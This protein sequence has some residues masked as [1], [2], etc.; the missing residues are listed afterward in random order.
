MGKRTGK[1]S[2]ARRYSIWKEAANS[3]QQFFDYFGRLHPGQFLI[4][5]LEGEGQFLVIEAAEVEQGG[6]EVAQV[7]W[8]G[9]RAV[10]HFVGLAVG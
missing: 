3:G 7:D 9:G 5:A 2:L 4:E 10:S 1:A 6:V 8:I